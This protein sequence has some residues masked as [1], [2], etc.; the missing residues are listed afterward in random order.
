MCGIAGILSLGEQAVSESALS[1]MVA[2]LTHRGPDDEGQVTLDRVGL[3]MRRLSIIGVANGHQ[4]IFNEDRTVA[5]VFNGEIYNYRELKADLL[6]RGH[7]FGTDSDAEVAV[8]LFEELGT[9]FVRRLRGMFALALYDQASDVLLLAR[10]RTGQKPLYYAT[11]EGRFVFGSEI[12]ALHASGYVPKELDRDGLTSY[13]VF[14]FVVGGGTLFRKVRRVDAGCLMTVGRRG[15]STERYWELPGPGVQSP[16]L[17]AVSDR[18]RALVEQAVEVRLMSEVPL[19]A[20]LSG[21][22]DSSVVVAMMAR[23]LEGSFQTFSVGFDDASD[24]LPHAELVARR[25]ATEHHEVLV[26]GCGP[27]LLRKINWFYDEPASDPAAVPTYCLSQYARKRI[28]V[29]LTGEG[30][31]ETFAGY[32]HYRNLMLVER[33]E[34]GL[35]GL[36]FLARSLGRLEPLLRGIP[37]S[38]FWKGIWLAGLPADER[39]RGWVS[40]FTD[41]ELLELMLSGNGRREQLMAVFRQLEAASS[42]TDPLAQLLYFDTRLTLADQLLMKVD[43]MSMASGLEARSPLLDHHLLEYVAALPTRLKIS[44]GGSKL[45]LREAFKDQLPEEIL[46]RPKQGFDVPLVRWLTRDLRPI[47]DRLLLGREPTIT[48]L[49][50][51]ETVSAIWRRVERSE[52]GR[53]ARQMW[54]LLNLAVWQDMHWPSAGMG[55][56]CSSGDE[57][58]EPMRARVKDF[59]S[60]A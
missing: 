6:Q 22:I 52:D 20:F 51:G 26:R 36:S 56:I 44:R 40:A 33:L 18:V 48:E 19:G 2:T 5:L 25:F 21:G 32:P 37:S 11:H 24:E 10:D 23:N 13:L 15:S 59:S 53:A 35:P 16:D 17:G 49:V 8:H 45:V 60:S 47:V 43:K 46:R 41:S 1:S 3:G 50:R 55:E 58:E 39:A 7:R 42:A 34:R 29:A 12:K 4:P 14:G 31:D 28:T 38:R 9:G 54:R 27:G 57:P 30:G